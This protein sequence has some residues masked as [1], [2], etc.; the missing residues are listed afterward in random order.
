ML[1]ETIEEARHLLAE[2][3]SPDKVEALAALLIPV[4]VLDPVAEGAG[5]QARLGGA[6]V[7]GA[8]LDWPVPPRPD[9]PAAIAAIGGETHG[10]A[11]RA[12]LEANR[13]YSFIGQVELAP[14]TA[15]DGTGDMPETGRL[16]F[17]YDVDTGPW[18][19][20][21]RSGRVIWDGTP[22]DEAEAKP[23]PPVLLEAEA[24]YLKEM[25]RTRVFLPPVDADT[26]ALM[27]SFIPDF[28]PEALRRE[29]ETIELKIEHHYLGPNAPQRI[30]RYWQLPVEYSADWDETVARF[31]RHLSRD[32][33]EMREPL[34]LLLS[35]IGE[36]YEG[37][38]RPGQ[39]A[40]YLLD[41]PLGEQDDPRYDAAIVSRYGVQF[42][43]PVHT[44]AE[45]DRI[46]EEARDWRLLFQVA[47]TAWWQDPDTEGTLYYLIREDDLA[48]RRFERVV[49]VY[50]QT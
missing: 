27:R 33:A 35:D 46:R 4:L 30:A 22:L 3:A 18:D 5:A 37:Q 20:G 16:L 17:F 32:P 14:L 6:P 13:P 28:D 47:L 50:Q 8:T 26:L 34:S 45:Y 44:R 19:T 12:A 9:D 49:T 31:A 11:I 39:E 48:A 42:M 21:T 10:P 41:Q 43:P 15:M 25:R 40:V 24:A 1:F 29:T 7:M 2:V 36:A 38:D 23:V